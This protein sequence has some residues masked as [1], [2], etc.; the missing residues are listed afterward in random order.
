MIH[1]N[2][3]LSDEEN[4]N[5]IKTNIVGSKYLFITAI[6]FFILVFVARIFLL[7]SFVPDLTVGE[8]N[9]VW[10]VQKTILGKDI[11]SDPG[12]LPFEVFQ[13]TPLV[14]VPVIVFAKLFNL[15]PGEDV[16]SFFVLGRSLSLLYN[17]GSAGIVF[18]LLLR[19]FH[20][21]R[22]LS[23]VAALLSFAL[24]SRDCFSFRPDAL[25]QFFFLA[26]IYFIVD[27]VQ[28]KKWIP[29]I[30]SA[31][32]ISLTVFSKQNG[33]QL[34]ITLTGFLILF[35]KPLFSLKYILTVLGVFGLFTLIFYFIYGDTFFVNTV[36]GI[37]LPINFIFA[38][39]ILDYIFLKYSLLLIAAI[40]IAVQWIFKKNGSADKRVIGLFT[41]G[42]L[43]FAAGTS[44]KVGSGIGYYNEGIIL[45]ILCVTIDLNSLLGK[46]KITNE[47]I[48]PLA[49]SFCIIMYFPFLI[50]NQ[51]FHE[52]ADNISH[53]HTD[54]YLKDQ[55]T[56][57]KVAELLIPGNS[58]FTPNKNIKNF[59]ITQSILP[60]TEF[61]GVSNTD[62]EA[63]TKL[64]DQGKIE[65]LL[66][67]QELKYRTLVHMKI[68]ISEYSAVARIDNLTLYRKNG[69]N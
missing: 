18:L 23:I 29:I 6:S 17:L 58:L 45:S 62:F 4:L 37:S 38:Y 49:F 48:I 22:N 27:A 42:A 21:S 24:M 63:V 47:K 14:Q 30:T 52:Y 68:N 55:K 67:D 34:I 15:V 16:H 36:G 35:G 8:D 60:N 1:E 10:N 65:L 53:R 39:Q 44:L 43:I 3:I 69:I 9:N 40:F 56:A 32:L 19:R 20:I 12:K 33:I 5:N 26:S 28:I 61:Y 64:S 57:M 11:Y 31:I 66:S 7:N 51:F 41:I 54:N 25:Y 46:L 13:Y 2:N 59:L 50:A